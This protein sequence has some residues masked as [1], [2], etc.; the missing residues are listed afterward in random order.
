MG[1]EL[2]RIQQ[3]Q[4]PFEFWHGFL[5]G[6]VCSP[7]ELVPTAWTNFLLDPQ[8]QGPKQAQEDLG[9]KPVTLALSLHKE[10]HEKVANYDESFFAPVT[11]NLDAWAEGFLSALGFWGDEY[12]E[13]GSFELKHLMQNALIVYNADQFYKDMGMDPDRHT[14]AEELSRA[15]SF[16]PF[17][18]MEIFKLWIEIH[19]VEHIDVV[20]RDLMQ[21]VKTE[22]E[23]LDHD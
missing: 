13:K 4:T 15:Q 17:M 16:L 19:E 12:I 8:G 21:K 14:R 6:I 10:M 3:A 23:K 18:V 7:I 1:E 22:L 2:N 20:D 5:A 11:Q 9:E